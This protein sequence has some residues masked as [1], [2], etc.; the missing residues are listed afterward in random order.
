MGR[1]GRDE[2]E[3]TIWQLKVL[4]ESAVCAQREGRP[5]N[6]SVVASALGVSRQQVVGAIERLSAIAGCEL[7]VEEADRLYVANEK[8]VNRA[9]SI[10]EDYR[11]FE[12][13]FEEGRGLWWLRLDG[14][15]AHLTLFMADAI[16]A[17]EDRHD[18]VRVELSGD[19]GTARLHGGAGLVAKLERGEADLV[20]APHIGRSIRED[21]DERPSHR[22]LLVAALHEQDGRLCDR[23]TLEQSTNTIEVTR[24]L[25]DNWSL[26]LSPKGHFSRDLLDLHQG[27]G[28]RFRVEVEG[29]EPDALVALAGSRDRV[30]I[31]ASDSVLGPSDHG[32]LPRHWPALAHEGNVLGRDYSV[33]VRRHIGRQH[34]TSGVRSVPHE[35]G[36]WLDELAGYVVDR[37]RRSVGSRIARWADLPLVGG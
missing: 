6:F 8:L 29:P 26:L 23:S 24:L 33:F 3:A 12:R 5:S 30:A 2:K 7:V 1:R 25:D 19:F 17:F 34:R 36:Q 14:Y 15:W 32:G 22:V 10:I 28:R 13:D 37:S 9:R 18:R 11:Q 21:I 35:V 31:V 16:R 20:T 27:P 4:V